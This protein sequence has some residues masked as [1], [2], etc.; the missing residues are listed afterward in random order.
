MVFLANMGLPTNEISII[1]AMDWFLGR[2]RTITNVNG[3]C[4][5]AAILQHFFHQ[6][7][8]NGSGYD[9]NP[10]PQDEIEMEEALSL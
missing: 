9:N 6:D 2:M 5:G 8:S 3:D 7:G 10:L 1:F 4:M